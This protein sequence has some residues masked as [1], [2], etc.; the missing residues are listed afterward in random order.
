M[1]LAVK[2]G[3]RVLSE[4][5]FN[6]GPVYIGRHTDSQVFLADRKVSRQHAVLFS[7]EDGHWMLEDLDSANKTYLNGEEI[8]KKEIK[9]GDVMAISDFSIE[10]SLEA[11]AAAGDEI[12][13][14]DT[15][16]TATEQ[17]R[18]IIRKLEGS[19]AN[20]VNLPSERI[21]DFV[22][23][24][25]R[26]CKSNGP[27]ELIKSLNK[28]LMKQFT[29][30]HCWC[31]VR[32]KAEG[33]MISHGG[34]KRD[35]SK[36]GLEGLKLH[37]EISRVVDKA[38]CLLFPRVLVQLGEDQIH[39]A[40]IVPIVGKGGCFGVLYLD[41]GMG[42]ESYTLSDVDYLLLLAIHTASV[43]ANF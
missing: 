16:T 30:F 42:H 19:G 17:Q 24:V 12:S 29:A 21:A 18:V 20:P 34:R 39:S 5:Q 10:I 2:K 6:K 35:S 1:R 9:D 25:D 14:E 22:E 31:A 32:D 26:I 40:M 11:E 33:A 28:V 23:A 36:V 8:R 7:T 15:L 41:N 3:E 13:L 4:L 27:D 37:E 43:V 38:Q